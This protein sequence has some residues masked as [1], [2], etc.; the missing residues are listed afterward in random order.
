MPLSHPPPQFSTALFVPQA[1]PGSQR[2]PGG[3][4]EQAAG[5]PGRRQVASAAA[6]AAA[7]FNGLLVPGQPLPDRG[8]CKH[9][10]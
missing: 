8:T 10:R 7:A 4:G 3:A 5:Q 9:Y 6:S 1:A 2:Q